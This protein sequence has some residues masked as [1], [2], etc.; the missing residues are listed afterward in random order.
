MVT[1]VAGRPNVHYKHR[2]D[3]GWAG[4]RDNTKQR[5]KVDQMAQI[6]PSADTTRTSPR[7]KYLENLKNK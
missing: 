1:I 2:R 4:E 6:F 5:P 7:R 3:W